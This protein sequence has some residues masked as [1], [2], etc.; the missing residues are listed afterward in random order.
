L[1]LLTSGPG[2]EENIENFARMWL[3]KSINR[4]RRVSRLLQLLGMLITA[5]YLLLTFI[6]TQ[7]LGSLIGNR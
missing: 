6:G 3:T 7:D 4:I 1:L 2:G 5:G